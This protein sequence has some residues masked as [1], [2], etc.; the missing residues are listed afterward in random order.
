MWS[1]SPSRREV[2]I[3]THATR[4]LTGTMIRFVLRAVAPRLFL[5]TFAAS[6]L[7]AST[8]GASYRTPL[9]SQVQLTSESTGWIIGAWGILKT[10]DGGATWKRLG[11]LPA[12]IAAPTPPPPPGWE[13]SSAR[14]PAGETEEH[15]GAAHRARA[16][17]LMSS[18]TSSLPT[19]GLTFCSAN[20]GTTPALPS[21]IGGSGDRNLLQVGIVT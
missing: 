12:H 5:L 18:A 11:T 10:E 4:P 20:S 1:H 16:W 19:S 2:D 13:P 8:Y 7:I 17:F 3:G 21:F 14:D 15:F 9:R 6:L